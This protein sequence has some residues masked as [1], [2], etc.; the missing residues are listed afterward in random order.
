LKNAGQHLVFCRN[1]LVIILLA[2]AVISALT[3]D[4][5]SLIIISTIVLMSAVLDT[6][7]GHARGWWK[8]ALS[9]LPAFIQDECAATFRLRQK[10]EEEILTALARD[11]HAS[12]VART[13]RDRLAGGRTGRHRADGRPHHQPSADKRSTLRHISTQAAALR[14]CGDPRL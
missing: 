13:L 12:R 9:A 2:A 14:P 10:K 8:S 6:W 5:T 4:P 11:A 3:G 7:A 1:P